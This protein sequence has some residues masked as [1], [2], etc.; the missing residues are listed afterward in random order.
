MKNNGASENDSNATQDTTSARPKTKRRKKQ[1]ESRGQ[2]DEAG[3]QNKKS[4]RSVWRSSSAF[5][6]AEFVLL[7]LTALGTV[8]GLI[9]YITVSVM[10]T[11]QT[12]MQ[13]APLVINSRPPEL[14]QP[15]TCDPKRG[16]YTG[17]MQTVVKNTGNARA[18]NVWPYTNLLTI[19]PERKT[20]NTF[21]DDPPP[22]NCDLTVN[23][24]E[25]TFTLAPGQEARPR[26]RQSAG[27][28]PELPE[29]ATVQ[30]Y[31]MSC[32]YYSDDY[33]VNHG[34]CDT[35]RL[36]LPSKNPLDVLGRSPS[37]VCDGAPRTGRFVGHVTGHC[38]K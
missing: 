1:R 13:Y 32:I 3:S 6:K 38:Q 14:L 7:G 25:A 16:L 17:N 19:I 8:G 12:Q 5:K 37:F 11:R 22:A 15:F 33:A 36:F 20:G 18:I 35:Y 28:V 21:V 27:T 9:A 26:I 4:W 2:P 10:Q 31:F 29:G 30:L 24:G 23:A 34:T